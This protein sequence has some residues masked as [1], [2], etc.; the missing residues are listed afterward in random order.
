MLHLIFLGGC[1]YCKLFE[2][3]AGYIAEITEIKK[4]RQTNF[5]HLVAKSGRCIEGQYVARG[6]FQ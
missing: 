5:G 3:F 4:G 2:N 1:Q 6:I